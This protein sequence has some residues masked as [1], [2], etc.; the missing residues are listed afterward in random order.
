M[1]KTPK[2]F[3]K[4][5]SA[6]GE[7]YKC[8]FYSFHLF[9]KLLTT[10]RYFT[11]FTRKPQEEFLLFKGNWIYTGLRELI[12]RPAADNDCTTGSVALYAK[13]TAKVPNCSKKCDNRIVP[14][15]PSP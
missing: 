5:D 15:K 12:F 14:N 6:R 13:S 2:K 11:T 8:N 3:P 7:V 4:L 9:S 10:M 1:T